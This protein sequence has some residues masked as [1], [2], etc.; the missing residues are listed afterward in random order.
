MVAERRFLELIAAVLGLIARLRDLNTQLMRSVAHLKRKRPPSETLARLENQ[1]ALPFPGVPAPRRRRKK[2][3]DEGNDKRRRNRHPGRRR[4]P[5]HLR[6]E[7][8]SNE[9]PEDLRTCP[10][11]QCPMAVLGHE[12][13]EVLEVR[14]AEVYVAVRKDETLYCA[15]DGIIVSAPPPDRIVPRGKLG[16]TFIVEALAD[17]YLLHVPIERQCTNWARRGV[18]I[19]PHTLGRS[20]AAAIDRLGPIASYIMAQA[21]RSEIISIDATGIRVLDPEVPEGRRYGTIWCG[22]GDGRWVSFLYWADGSHEGAAG[23]LGTKTELAGRII[24]CDGTST[25]NFIESGGGRRPGCWAHARRGLVKAARGGDL[26]AV[27]GLRIIAKLFLVE[28]V[29]S[30]LHESAEQ[31]RARRQEQSAIV[32]DEL[33]DWVEHHRGLITPK[34]PL[35]K[36]LGY[37]HRQW[38]RLLLFVEDGRIEATN[39]HVERSLRPLVLGLKNWLFTYDDIGAERTAII[40]SVIGTCVAQR[41]NPRAFLHKALA[42]LVQGWDEDKMHEL[43]PERL[44]EHY[45]ELRMPARASPDP[46]EASIAELIAALEQAIVEAL[47]APDSALA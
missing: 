27:E 37:M 24:Q 18:D 1:L 47:P 17:K 8:W 29:A 40:L 35:G 42:L 39:N 45:P 19:P 20:V 38:A 30:A 12:S 34:S 10:K 26:L 36:A 3:G 11:C 28:R 22:I 43:A 41:I 14:P 15:K 13:C 25:T 2:K 21:R 33:H 31:R 44:A 6:R 9:V 32:L 7:E 46:D 5:A 4:L 23:L 16:D